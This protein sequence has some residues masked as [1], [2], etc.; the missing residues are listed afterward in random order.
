M[1][2]AACSGYLLQRFH[3]STGPASTTIPETNLSA[4]GRNRCQRAGLA[5]E[6]IAR[7]PLR[8]IAGAN[9]NRAGR[10]VSQIN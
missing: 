6:L 8:Y 3:R 1:D 2:I 9:V 10:A 4:G 5:F 7:F